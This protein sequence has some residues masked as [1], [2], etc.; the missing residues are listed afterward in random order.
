MLLKIRYRCQKPVVRKKGPSQAT[1]HQQTTLHMNA[2]NQSLIATIACVPSPCGQTYSGGQNLSQGCPVSPPPFQQLP[3]SLVPPASGEPEKRVP[4]RCAM[5]RYVSFFTLPLAV[6]VGEA[7][8]RKKS[9]YTIVRSIIP[10]RQPP[11]NGKE[12]Y[13]NAPYITGIPGVRSRPSF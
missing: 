12:R 5:D 13:A 8:E 9:T 3:R 4:M 11:T 10:H 6:A 2:C 7:L 1:E